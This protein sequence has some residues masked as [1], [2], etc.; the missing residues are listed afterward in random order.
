MLGLG[1]FCFSLNLV[2]SSR[3]DC[4]PVFSGLCG[5]S[6]DGN[7]AAEMEQFRQVG[8]VVGGLK[9]LMVLKHDI[10]INQR[11]CCLLFDMFVLAFETISDEIR[12]NL[13]LDDRSINWKPLEYPMKELYRVFKEG[14]QYIRFCLDFNNWWGKAIS[15]HLNRDCVEFHIHNLLTCF[16]VVIEAIETVA[17]FSVTELERYAVA[18]NLLGKKIDASF[19]KQSEKRKVQFHQLWQSMR[20]GFETYC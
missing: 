5:L 2:A 15:L 18:W 3:L 12:Q 13:R 16:P 11:Q 1:A 9:A 8:E 4:I 6:I 14:E 20:T 17:E 19:L 10:P 7:S